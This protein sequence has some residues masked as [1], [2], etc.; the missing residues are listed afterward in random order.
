MMDF[1]AIEVKTGMRE[2]MVVMVVSYALLREA[3]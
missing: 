2:M 1:S 3:R